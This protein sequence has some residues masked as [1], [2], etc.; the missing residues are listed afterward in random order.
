M[1][2]SFEKYFIKNYSHPLPAIINLL[3][4]RIISVDRICRQDIAFW[5]RGLLKYE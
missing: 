2:D 4:I 5:S 1:P 3:A